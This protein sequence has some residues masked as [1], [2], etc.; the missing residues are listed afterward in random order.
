MEKEKLVTFNNHENKPLTLFL[1]Q[2]IGFRKLDNKGMTAILVA[3]GES[4][5]ELWINEPYPKVYVMLE[6]I[7]NP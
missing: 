7:I 3:C 1:S 5:D 4:S 2:I 6:E